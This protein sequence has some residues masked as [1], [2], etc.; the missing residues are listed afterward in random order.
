MV[1]VEHQC[2]DPYAAVCI[3]DLFAL[4]NAT[5]NPLWARAGRMIWANCSQCIAGK[6]GMY[7]HGMLRPAGAQNE[8]FAQ[9]RWSKY[10]TSPEARGHLNDFIG[11]W[12]CCFKLYAMDQLG[13]ARNLLERE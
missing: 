3:P 13:D 12:L 9:T 4:S 10:R 1:S 11:I 6:D 7:L 5:K 2:I 8:C